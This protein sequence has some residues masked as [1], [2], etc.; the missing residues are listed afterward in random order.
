MEKDIQTITKEEIENWR[1]TVIRKCIIPERVETW[2]G[3]DGMICA[4]KIIVTDE[5]F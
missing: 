2:T 1:N 5:E 3:T 4:I